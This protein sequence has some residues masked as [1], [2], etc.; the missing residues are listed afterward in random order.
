MAQ[1]IVHPAAHRHGEVDPDI[2]AAFANPIAVYT[3]QGDWD[4]T[5]H[6]GFTATGDRL[7]EVGFAR[8]DDP[9]DPPVVVH[10]MTA[11]AKYVPRRSPG[12]SRRTG[13]RTGR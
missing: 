6:I 10:A 7:L 3:D 12:H 5:M 11:R 13:P 4:L 2:L 9:A 1:P 8:S